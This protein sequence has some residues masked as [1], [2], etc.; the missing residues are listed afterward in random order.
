MTDTTT[1]QRATCAG[2]GDTAEMSFA[3]AAPRP[4]PRTAP[5]AL[6]VVDSTRNCARMS[7]RFAPSDF[8]MPISN[9]RSATATSM[10]FMITIAPTTRPMA[11]STI[12]ASTR[13][14][15]IFSQEVRAEAA[16]SST[17]SSGMA[18]CSRWRLRITSRTP[19]SIPMN[20]W[21]LGAWMTMP[22]KLVRECVMRPICEWKGAMT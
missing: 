1:D 17:K 2:S 16:L 7:R 3:K 11:G 8:R 21:V 6:S 14:F 12:P 10:M 5:A 13:Y 19:C 4:T 9:V 15:R 22:Y 18:G 20:A